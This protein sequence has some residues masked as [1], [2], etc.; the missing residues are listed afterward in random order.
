VVGTFALMKAYLVNSSN[1]DRSESPGKSTMRD[2]RMEVERGIKP[3][4]FQHVLLQ[5]N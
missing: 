3:P 1:K 5:D 4:P 2:K